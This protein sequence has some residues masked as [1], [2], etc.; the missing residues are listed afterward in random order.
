MT[1]DEVFEEFRRNLGP[2]AEHYEYIRAT[3]LVAARRFED[4]SLDFVFVDGSH[5]FRDVL[6]DLEAWYPKVRAGG[7]LAGHDYHWPEVR[8]AVREFCG[9]GG[10]NTPMPVELCWVIRRPPDPRTRWDRLRALIRIPLDLAVYAAAWLRL[11]V[12]RAVGS[13]PKDDEFYR[14]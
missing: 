6:D 8:R 5:A 7:T 13:R 14:P 2:V 12:L 11:M 9:A 3:S 10:L 1:A 4:G